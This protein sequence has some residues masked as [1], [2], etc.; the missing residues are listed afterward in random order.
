MLT[1]TRTFAAAV[2][3]DNK[4]DATPIADLRTAC[5][6]MMEWDGLAPDT[7]KM[8]LASFG[9]MS[10]TEETKHI[11]E[12]HDRTQREMDLNVLL[13]HLMGLANVIVFDGAKMPGERERIREVRIDTGVGFAWLITSK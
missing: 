8:D 10:K 4:E 1:S 7:V 3:W 13:M 9:A 5:R 2:G 12:I 11:W 6:I